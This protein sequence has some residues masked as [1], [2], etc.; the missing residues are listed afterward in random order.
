[1]LFRIEREVFEFHRT[2]VKSD[3]IAGLSEYRSEL[4]H[5]SALHAAVIVL[6][7]LTDARK[8]ELV[9]SEVKEIIEGISE[10]AFKSCRRRHS[11]SERNVTGKNSVESG[12]LSASLDDLAAYSEDIACPAL[13]WSILLIK[14]EFAI[15]IKVESKSMHLISAVK[16]DLGNHSLVDSTWE[17]ESSIV[18]SMFSDK[19]YASCG[20]KELTLG[21]EKGLEFFRNSC[22]HGNYQFYVINSCKFPIMFG[23]I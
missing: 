14:S 7:A 22:L 10:S 13:M 21:I 4:V 1:M 19:V 3:E 2:A 23:M 12:N 16:L 11:C 20:C 9:D 6:C 5:D 17:Y 15:L 8:L 18:I